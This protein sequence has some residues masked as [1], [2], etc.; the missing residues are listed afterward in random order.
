MQLACC[1]ALLALSAPVAA[2][3]APGPPGGAAREQA[4]AVSGADPATGEDTAAAGDAE[5][6][7]AVTR[8]ELAL[9]VDELAESEDFAAAAARLDE[10]LALTEEE[11]GPESEMLAETYTQAASIRSGNGDYQ[12]AEEDAL[13]AIEIY[14]RAL[15]TYVRE[16]IDPYLV[17][18]DAYHASGDYASAL[19]AYD[20]ARTVSRRVDGLLNTGQIEI[21]DRMTESAKR[22]NQL[23]EADSLQ[24]EALTVVERANEPDSPETIDAVFKYALWLRDNNL[25]RREREQYARVDRLIRKKYGDESPLLVR[26]LRERANSFRIQGIEDSL[27]LSGIRDALE[28]LELHPDTLMAAETLRDLGDWEVA[29]S[30]VGTSGENYLRSW[31]LLGELENG[32][33]LRR[34]W[35]DQT[36][37]VLLS[38]LSQRGLSSDPSAPNGHV[39]VHFTVDTQGRTRDVTIVE[40]DPPGLKDEA[41]LRMFRTSRFRPRIVDGALTPARRAYD[42][43][44]KYAPPEE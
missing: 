42:I 38:P 25:F 1:V 15:G 20:E 35:Y 28:I 37:R 5:A 4:P 8:F 30:R 31:E 3:D 44:F 39:V 41:V 13:E 43:Q 21:I 16:M 9:E 27:G 7:A 12:R 6:A 23:E 40:S 19:S 18:G 36:H 32:G 2:Q 33:K 24:V 34:E 11:F 26:G 22:L 10:L 14:R 17:L 29:F